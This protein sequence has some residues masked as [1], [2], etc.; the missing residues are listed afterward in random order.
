[1]GTQFFIGIALILI[2]AVL[3]FVYRNENE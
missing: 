1:M 2:M 3:C